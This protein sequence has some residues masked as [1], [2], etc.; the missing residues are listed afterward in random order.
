VCGDRTVARSARLKTPRKASLR[1]DGDLSSGTGRAP[2]PIHRLTVMPRRHQ[3]GLWVGAF[4]QGM[5][6]VESVPF[7]GRQVK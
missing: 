2:P 1:R 5:R 3:P 4:T 7:L 6:C